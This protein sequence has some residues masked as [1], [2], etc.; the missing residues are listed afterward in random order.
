MPDPALE[1]TWLKLRVSDIVR[2]AEGISQFEFTDPSNATLPR[3]TAGA[4]VEIRLGGDMVR[5]YS[6]SNNP[7]E[8]HRYV[9]AVL[10]EQAG[11]GGSVAMHDRVKVGDVLDVS[12]PIN[13]FALAGEE[14]RFH[15]LLAGGIGVTPMM[16]MIHEL[17]TRGAAWH[18][19]YC[20]RSP[21]R[22]AFKSALAPHIAA[23]KVTLHHDGGDPTRGLDLA[24]T[25]T[26]FE[27]GNHIYFCGPSGFMSATKAA[28]VSWPAHTVHFE[29][30]SASQD[31]KDA[32]A[33]NTPFEIKI[34]ST[35]KVLE[36]PADKSILDV[37]RANGLTV[38][39]DCEDGFCGTCI[40]R[41][42]SGEPD[43]RDTVLSEGER[44]S[45]MMLCCSRAKGMLELD[46]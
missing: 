3:F 24:A 12:T 28:L 20:T 11:R 25:L 35:G 17:E 33:E 41:F 37:L 18:M 9:V 19:H 43:H 36:V 10:R 5:S 45:Y 1:K 14:A 30:F 31:A 44:R 46:L 22:T 29:Y 7:A 34:R 39:S 32:Q 21:D 38:E 2:E 6:L 16:A 40:T 42:V 4:H 27:V 26:K 8:T 15:L 23:G 13:R